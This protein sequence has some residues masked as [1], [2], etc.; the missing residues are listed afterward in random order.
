MK[1]L[2]LHDIMRER[3]LKNVT[4]TEIW[5]QADGSD[6][7][8]SVVTLGK[9]QWC[10]EFE[11]LMRNRL[12]LGYHRY[13]CLEDQ[14]R[15]GGNG[16]DNVGSAIERLNLFKKK[17]GNQEYL[18]DSANLCLVEF[19]VGSHPKKHFKAIDDGI[20]VRKD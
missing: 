5:P 16:F 9:L 6:L 18:V 14:K 2:T 19:M 10:P 12:L 3:L 15:Q 4:A 11:E 13:G 20:H 8:P 17:T 1:T 7:A